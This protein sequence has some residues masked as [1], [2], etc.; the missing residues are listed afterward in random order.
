MSARERQLV[1]ALRRVLELL[2]SVEPG[3]PETS[4]RAIGAAQAAAE[5]ALESERRE[6]SR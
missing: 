1:R 3:N 5:M 2:A 6:S 4:H